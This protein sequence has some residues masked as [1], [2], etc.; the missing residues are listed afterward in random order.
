MTS[1]LELRTLVGW[2]HSSPVQ[3]AHLWQMSSESA[4]RW[5][6]NQTDGATLEDR[7]VVIVNGTTLQVGEIDGTT[8]KSASEVSL[9][10]DEVDKT[11]TGGGS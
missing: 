11:A 5:K 1:L 2:I 4:G 6:D 3:T 10:F 9:E 8:L 7:Q